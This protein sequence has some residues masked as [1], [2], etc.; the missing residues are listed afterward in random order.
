MEGSVSAAPEQLQRIPDNE[1]VQESP[2]ET[3]EDFLGTNPS[4]DKVV[5]ALKLFLSYLDKQR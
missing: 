3:V 4:L 2:E 5:S 1:E